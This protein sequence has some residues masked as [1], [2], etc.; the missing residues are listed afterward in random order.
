M[1]NLRPDENLRP[2]E[3]GRSGAAPL[4]QARPLAHSEGVGRCGIFLALAGLT[5]GCTGDRYVPLGDLEG[6]QSAILAY[7]VPSGLIRG[8]AIR[9]GEPVGPIEFDGQP[10]E[11]EARL[12]RYDR[13]LEE[14]YLPAGA[15]A[16]DPEGRVLPLD[17]LE[18][19]LLWMDGALGWG[20]S[21]PVGQPWPEAR[22]SYLEHAP[23]RRRVQLGYVAAGPAEGLDVCLELTAGERCRRTDR[24]GVVELEGLSPADE[25]LLVAR[26]YGMPP[27]LYPVRTPDNNDVLSFPVVSN[28]H[29]SQIL[30]KVAVTVSSTAGQV[31]FIVNGP[32]WSL[33][34]AKVALTPAQGQIYYTDDMGYLDPS[35][36]RTSPLGIDGVLNVKPGT[37]AL[38]VTEPADCRREFNA[39][40]APLPSQTTLPIRAGHLTWG[41]AFFCP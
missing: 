38:G 23:A 9:A 41:H 3:S 10:E 39:W 8:L 6:A 20:P 37:V 15:L 12:I 28:D 11:V 1:P 19:R 2:K 18:S 32:Q 40:E 13:T 33:A 7:R 16:T 30:H 29:F 14:L 35:R 24:E 31:V 25:V 27:H 5:W 17:G 26:G 22:F 21:E 34:N 36:D 4:D